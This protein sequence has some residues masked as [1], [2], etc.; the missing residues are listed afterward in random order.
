M[1]CQ[2]C[3]YRA[4]CQFDKNDPRV[5][6]RRLNNYKANDVLQRVKREEKE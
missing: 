4:V 2:Y 5:A 3:E 1:P 6:S